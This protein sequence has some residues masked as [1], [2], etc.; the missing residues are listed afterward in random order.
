MCIRDRVWIQRRW[1]RRMGACTG[2]RSRAEGRG[3]RQR[4]EAEWCGSWR[5]RWPTTVR[6]GRTEECR[7][8][9]ARVRADR[10]GSRRVRLEEP[11]GAR[12]VEETRSRMA[13][14]GE[15]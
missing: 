8:T 2:R 6:F 13:R 14:A 15:E 12:R 7:R 9:T 4:L 10:C 1:G 11:E 5:G 3:T